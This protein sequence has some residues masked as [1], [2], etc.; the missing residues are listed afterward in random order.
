MGNDYGSLRAVETHFEEANRTSKRPQH[1]YTKWSS[2][3]DSIMLRAG[4]SAGYI[5]RST[6]RGADPQWVKEVAVILKRWPYEISD[7]LEYLIEENQAGRR[8]SP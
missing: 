5:R 3:E 7:R 8:P 2:H 4:V 1:A 6:H